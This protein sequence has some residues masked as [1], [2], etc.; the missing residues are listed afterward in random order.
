MTGYFVIIGKDTPSDSAN[1]QRFLRRARD[2][3]LL[4]GYLR[5]QV[6][7]LKFIPWKTGLIAE[8]VR[9]SDYCFAC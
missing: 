3:S 2:D 8:I 6:L 1:I 9:S 5:N 4:K 7:S